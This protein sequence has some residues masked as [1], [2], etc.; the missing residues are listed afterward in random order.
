[1]RLSNELELVEVLP[2]FK[3]WKKWNWPYLLNL[4]VY[5]DKSL[6]THYYWHDLDRG[7]ANLAQEIAKCHLTSVKAVSS[8]KFWKSENGQT[9]WTFV[10]KLYIHIDIDKM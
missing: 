2:R 3:F 1:M 7:I 9:E 4:M 5:F 8:S 10:M 6:H